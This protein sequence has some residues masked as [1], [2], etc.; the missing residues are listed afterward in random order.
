MSALEDHD[1]LKMDDEA[2]QPIDETAAAAADILNDDG[3][4]AA[5]K[6]DP[7]ASVEEGEGAT[8]EPAESD[9]LS[10]RG[11]SVNA[12]QGNKKFRALC[13]A[14]KPVSVNNARVEPLLL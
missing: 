6:E 8:W 9:V 5:D 13:F 11:A 7:E 12:H 4:V 2:D 14:R 10:G 1:H 3:C